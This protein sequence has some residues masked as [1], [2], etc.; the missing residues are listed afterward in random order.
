MFYVMC[1]LPQLEKRSGGSV[2]VAP[3]TAVSSQPAQSYL[4][5]SQLRNESLYKQAVQATALLTAGVS[6]FPISSA[7]I[8]LLATLFSR[9][10]KPTPRQS[11]ALQRDGVVPIHWF[12]C[13]QK[14]VQQVNPPKGPVVRT[15]QGGCVHICMWF[16]SALHRA[17]QAVPTFSDITHVVF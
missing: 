14:Y 6:E 15:Q 8:N 16:A 3:G 7:N 13:F 1:I 12:N 10:P 4:S 2:Q 17:T 9:P 11:S 5:F